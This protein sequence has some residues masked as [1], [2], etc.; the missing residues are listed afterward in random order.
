MDQVF[1]HEVREPLRAIERGER[2]F[3]DAERVTVLEDQGPLAE[4]DREAR[5]TGLDF[6]SELGESARRCCIFGSKCY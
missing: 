6:E 4:D 2:F 1:R 5:R 3:R